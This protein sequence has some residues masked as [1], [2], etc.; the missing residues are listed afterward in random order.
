VTV[1]FLIDAQLPPL[2][3][4]Y[5]SESGHQA[6]HVADL[7]LSS[8]PDRDIWNYALA[9]GA[10]LITKDEDFITMRALN[11]KGPAIV[12]VRLGNTT[13]RELLARISSTLPA[14]L[15]GLQRG[16]TVIEVSGSDD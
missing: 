4:R 7:K 6:E 15:S 13:R 11:A 1:R 8:A 12:W 9:N 16:E 3:A 10:V 5:L 2:L 14:I